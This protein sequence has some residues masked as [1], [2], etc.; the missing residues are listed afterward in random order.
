MPLAPIAL[1]ACLLV[2]LWIVARPQR[3]LLLLAA[4]LPFDGLLVLADH[5]RGVAG[6]KEALLA[7][8][9]GAAL[10]RSVAG[11]PRRAVTVVPAFVVP[12][13]AL[14]A[15]A[16][17]SAALV[18]ATQAAVGLKIGFLFVLVGVAAWLAP[19]DG[20]DR[21]RL[22]T[23]L[24]ATGVVAAAYGL[25]Q[26][27]AGIDRLE[28]LGY[29]FDVNLRT[30]HGVLRSIGPFEQPFPFAFFL[31][32]VLL[33]AGAAALA[34]PA[35]RRSRAFAAGLVLV[36][37]ALAFTFVRGA[38]LALAA[39]IAY[40]GVTRYRSLFVVVPVVVV[41]M[42]VLPGSL[43]GPAASASSLGTRQEGWTGH[44]GQVVDHP[45]GAGLATTGAAAEKVLEISGRDATVFEPDNQYVKTLLELG[46]LG[47]WLFGLV[48]LGVLTELRRAERVLAGRDAALAAGTTAHV[49]AACVAM[50]VATYLEIFPMDAY[51][52]LLVGVVVTCARPSS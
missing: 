15:L 46:V 5:P 28:R 29:R 25:W 24:V 45:L 37:P 38:W 11:P 42:L 26:Q 12:L 7:V 19:L 23:I 3:G 48:L 36:V 6:W 16:L 43:L 22:V 20:R 39:G 30:T 34:E 52:W 44:L 21:D 33:V 1:A 2:A 8:T 10:V 13:A 51:T 47:L 14:L 49:V 9:V 40:L 35:R 32:M 18:P 27:V 17:V 50:L 31:T 41:A 4:A